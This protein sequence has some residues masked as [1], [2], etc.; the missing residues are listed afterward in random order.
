MYSELLQQ[1]Q[2]QQSSTYE[3][4]AVSSSSAAASSG[5][6]RTW[7]ESSVFHGDS[8][9]FGGNADS[10]RTRLVAGKLVAASSVAQRGASSFQDQP[11]PAHG[12]YKDTSG[13]KYDRQTNS[14]HRLFL[15]TVSN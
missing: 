9:A 6:R 4:K 10:M 2:K 11:C 1:Q 8:L 12:I 14:G 15:P 7:A 3:T 13:F 5:R